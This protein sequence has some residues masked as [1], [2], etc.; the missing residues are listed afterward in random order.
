[1]STSEKPHDSPTGENPQPASLEEVSRRRFLHRCCI[2]LGAACGAAMCAPPAGFLIAPLFEKKSQ[3]WRTVGHVNQFEIGRTVQVTFLD[4]S[5]LPW[6]G[7]AARSAAWLRRLDK[8]KFVA[9]SIN[10][11][12]LGCPVRWEGGSELFLCPCHG[13][14]YYEDGSVAAGPP[15]AP[16]ARYNVRVSE[17]NV[18]LMP[19][20]IRFA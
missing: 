20:P 5:P 6:A 17:N 10:C 2:G 16:L 3:D 13:G 1:M 8:E 4:S 12:H 9:F 15:P 11:T 18:Q 19:A 14:V 7:V